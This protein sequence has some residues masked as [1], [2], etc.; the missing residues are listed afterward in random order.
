[1]AN[2]TN[3]SQQNSDDFRDQIERIKQIKQI[4]EKRKS[5][6]KN[7][8]LPKTTSEN[9]N[10]ENLENSYEQKEKELKISKLQIEVQKEQIE[11]QKEQEKVFKLRE[12]LHKQII[13][14]EKSK[15]EI[16]ILKQN[17]QNESKEHDTRLTYALYI[18][19]FVIVYIFLVLVCTILDAIVPFCWF[20]LTDKT[21]GYLLGTTAVSVIGLLASSMKYLLYKK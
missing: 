12:Q 13:D 4:I 18:F 5:N 10:Y 16:D 21:L 17:A 2:S 11:V 6:L 7:T 1:M 20:D 14:N 3:P 9:S 19:G 15:A 8:Q